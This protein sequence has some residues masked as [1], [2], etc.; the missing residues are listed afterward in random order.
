VRED[1]SKTMDCWEQVK[2]AAQHEAASRWRLVIG[3]SEAAAVQKAES[4]TV[5]SM[6]QHAAMVYSE[7]SETV[8][9]GANC[10][11]AGQMRRDAPD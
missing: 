3:K 2:V 11:R 1:C 9:G 6:F 5:H 7:Q 4:T 8:R 10:V